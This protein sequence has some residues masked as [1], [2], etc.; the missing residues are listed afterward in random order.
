[1]IRNGLRAVPR[2]DVRAWPFGGKHVAL[3]NVDA[4]AEP[5]CMTASGEVFVRVSGQ[6]VSK[7][8]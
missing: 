8:S 4:V 1:V 7:R 5:P 6:Q 2:Y 3:V